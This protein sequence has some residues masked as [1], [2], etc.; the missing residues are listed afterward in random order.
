MTILSAPSFKYVGLSAPWRW[1][2]FWKNVC[3]LS[4][5]WSAFLRI[6]TKRRSVSEWVSEY[7]RMQSLYEEMSFFISQTP[8]SWYT[9]TSHQSWIK[10]TTLVRRFLHSD[11]PFSISLFRERRRGGIGTN[12]R[13]NERY[14][15]IK[16]ST[17]NERDSHTHK[18]KT[19]LHKSSRFHQWHTKSVHLLLL[20]NIILLIMYRLNPRLHR[21][22]E[23][24][25]RERKEWKG[26]NETSGSVTERDGKTSIKWYY[27]MC[28]ILTLNVGREDI[29]VLY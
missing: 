9:N 2:S 4:T 28:E 3:L 14:E 13:T 27:E 16:Y 18:T 17:T 20:L 10:N 24:E 26:E 1:L 6:W 12:E 29:T 19:Y 25:E 7:E 8:S 15:Y 23:R 11:L 22:K 21:E 5:F